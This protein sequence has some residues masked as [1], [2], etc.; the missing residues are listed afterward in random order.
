MNEF[1]I[2]NYFYVWST[3]ILI[4]VYISEYKTI[5]EFESIFLFSNSC[6]V[7]KHIIKKS[8]VDELLQSLG[9]K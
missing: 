7:S 8:G 5:Q 2:F 9:M 4:Y 3:T 1:L 6:Q